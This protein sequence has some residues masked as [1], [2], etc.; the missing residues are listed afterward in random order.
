MDSSLF[1]AIDRPLTYGELAKLAST[2]TAVVIASW[3]IGRFVGSRL[4]SRTAMG[5]GIRYAL[6]CISYYA[7]LTLG[8]IIA[9]QSS[10][11]DLQ[12]LTVVLAL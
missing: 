8:L 4:L 6:G 5:P 9:L 7:V 11:I 12:S 2:L 10:G 1:L 3:L